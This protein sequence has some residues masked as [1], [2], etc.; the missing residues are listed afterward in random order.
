VNGQAWFYKSTYV[1]SVV[2]ADVKEQAPKSPTPPRVRRLFTRGHHRH[3]LNT[4]KFSRHCSR[5]ASIGPS[6]PQR[7]AA[8]SRHTQRRTTCPWTESLPTNIRTASF[9]H[10]YRAVLCIAHTMPSFCHFVCLSVTRRYSLETA[11]HITKL[12]H[13]LVAT[14]V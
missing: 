2:Y 9:H 4:N 12:C 13:P 5:R 14:P 8:A 10:F 6:K 11:K 7:A 3:D 1:L